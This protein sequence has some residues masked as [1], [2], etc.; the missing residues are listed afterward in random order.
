MK[1]GP[2][3]LSGGC[4]VVSSGRVS[5]LEVIGAGVGVTDKAAAAIEGVTA[6]LVDVIEIDGAAVIPGD[7]DIACSR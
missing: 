1:A 4:L 5:F 2:R 7:P 6:L 3:E